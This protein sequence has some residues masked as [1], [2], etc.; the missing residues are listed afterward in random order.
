MTAFPEKADSRRRHLRAK[1]PARAQIGMKTYNVTDM[2]PEGFRVKT[3]GLLLPKDIGVDIRLTFPF[4]KF[5]M[6]FDASAGKVYF[7]RKDKAAGFMFRNLNASQISLLN[8]IV[9]SCFAGNI[10]PAGDHLE[11]ISRDN[12]VDSA[13]QKNKNLRNYLPE[14]QLS[15][16]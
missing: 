9:K 8:F 7:S 16:K 5:A 6:Q 1:I 3:E 14:D 2:S 10:A 4:N 15:S 11:I 12:F 13:R